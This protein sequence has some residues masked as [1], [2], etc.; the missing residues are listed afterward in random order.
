MTVTFAKMEI[1]M[2][3][4]VIL[5]YFEVK[6]TQRDFC[7]KFLADSCKY[8]ST[9]IA[10]CDICNNDPASCSQCKRG[11]YKTFGANPS[12]V[13]CLEATS[14]IAGT[15]LEIRTGLGKIKTF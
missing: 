15:E 9:A 4:K 13:T 12:C 5:S 6:Q 2:S 11:Y 8:C 10:N 14:F 3:T 7:F 1:N